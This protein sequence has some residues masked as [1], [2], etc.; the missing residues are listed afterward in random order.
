MDSPLTV[1]RA[2][3]ILADP[4][5]LEMLMI[6]MD[7]RS[8]PAT[9]LA[10]RAHVSNS[11]ASHHL[12][13]LVEAEFVE[14]YRQGRHRYHRL[15]NQRVADAIESLGLVAS[16]SAIEDSPE[17]PLSLGRSC[18][19]HLAGRLGVQ[20]RLSLES[21]QQIRRVGDSYE[22]TEA[23]IEFIAK[24]GFGKAPRFGKVCL[25]WTERQPHIGGELG[26]FL[27]R[28]WLE[29]GWIVRG[30]IPRQILLT[31]DGKIS[32]DKFHVAHL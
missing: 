22:V 1:S 18:Y 25:D 21:G 4:T 19:S 32:L 11:T 29:K 2:A 24:L 3:A 12:A 27:F 5:R 28:A 23:G 31:G 13:L 10:A 30:E 17:G 8:F 9:E 6:L 15:A 20:L 16:P 26:R 14:V 7:G